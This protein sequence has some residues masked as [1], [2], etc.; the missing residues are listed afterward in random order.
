[1]KLFFVGFFVDGGNFPNSWNLAQM[2][3]PG[4]LQRLGACY[5]FTALIH[6]WIPTRRKSPEQIEREGLEEY[7]QQREDGGGD[8]GNGNGKPSADHFRV[9][10]KYAYQLVAAGVL[11]TVY[12]LITFLTQVPLAGCARGSLNPG[13]SAAKYWDEQIFGASH[14]YATPTYNRSH[15]CSNISPQ[16]CPDACPVVDRPQWCDEPFDPEGALS[17]IAAIVSCVIGLFF[18]H[19]LEE[20]KRHRARIDQWSAF[21]VVSLVIGLIVHF[22]LMPMNKN[23]WSVS[24][25]LVMAGVDGLVM[26]AFYFLIDVKGYKKVV[27]PMIC[28]V[29]STGRL[30]TRQLQP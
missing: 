25:V 3:V 29:S 23:I 17:S 16:P 13:C 8:V 22:T 14:M 9:Y 15:W 7:L 28:M 18:G 11:L 19:I 26:A 10:K 20:E 4:I 12:I 27:H 21:S 24:F 2:R 1:M 5:F 6:I 30:V